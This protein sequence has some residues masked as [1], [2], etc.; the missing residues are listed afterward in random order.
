MADETSGVQ[1]NTTTISEIKQEMDPSETVDRKLSAKD[2]LANR[3]SLRLLPDLIKLNTS[4]TVGRGGKG[5]VSLAML[6]RNASAQ[7]E[8]V[9]V[10]QL[11][12]DSELN[13]DKFSKAFAHEV[14]L[15]AGLA[16][17][18]IVQ[19]IGFVEDLENDKAWVVFPWEANGN[20]REFLASGEWEI[21]E[22]LS[23]L[24]DT[25][26]GL[27][28]LHN[29]QPPICHGDLK[30]YLDKTIRKLNILVSSTYRATITDFG[31]ARFRKKS[32]EA[33]HRTNQDVTLVPTAQ[34]Y[35]PSAPIN[36]F[37]TGNQLTLTGPA[38]SLRWAAPEILLQDDV[39]LPSDIWA[40]GWV[41]WEAG[42]ITLKVVQGEFPSVK[43]DA[44]LSQVVRLGSLMMDCWTFDPKTRPT[45]TQC[46]RRLFFMPHII[47][48]GGDAPNSKV[49]S[50]ALLLRLASMRSAQGRDESATSLFQ[51]A[52]AISK[53]AGDKPATAEASRGFGNIHLAHSRYPEAEKSFTEA[54]EI[55]TEISD[56]LGIED[57]LR[58]L[59][60]IYR[61]TDR[62]AEAERSFLKAKEVCARIHD[63]I[64]E[65]SALRALGDIYRGLGKYG[66]AEESYIQARAIS[67]ENVDDLGLTNVL[68]GLGTLYRLS[69][70]YAEAE[71]S[72]IQARE[73]CARTG[74][75][76]AQATVLRGL[77]NIS[78]AQSN[79]A[80]AVRWFIQ[81][82]AIS[83]RIGDHLGRGHALRGLGTAYRGQR[84]YDESEKSFNEAG[85]VYSRVGNKTG[86]ANVLFGLGEL[87][88]EQ[89]KYSEA[90]VLYAEARDLYVLIGALKGQEAASNS[91]AAVSKEL[92]QLSSLS[93]PLNQ[94]NPPGSYAKP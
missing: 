30:S 89:A 59:G 65:S 67:T 8:I 40:A 86:R 27:E 39:D 87:R 54:L 88:R 31:S 90:L 15:L 11:R 25:F 45:A 77:G 63:P 72:L 36:V 16:H 9:A 24:V 55:S 33:A 41:A 20:V 17:P 14:D 38:W 75:D 44:E 56:D 78:D 60:E 91:L 47:P 76:L 66:Q 3:S 42:A 80:E 6:K 29:R 84:M 32:S 48:S 57:A 74:D 28:Y 10:K 18:N 5:D 43:D 83:A 19:L 73:V 93:A 51:Q 69:G 62:Y 21:P 1:I 70:R 12:P 64:G 7:E 26:S 23:L 58:G 46:F 81:A 53:P 4:G 13:E 52:L 61:L 79:H 35:A 68:N 37:A 82:E 49:R 92:G 22:R 50:T 71:R 94:A 2:I 34:E 85:E